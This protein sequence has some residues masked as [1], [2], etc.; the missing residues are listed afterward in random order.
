MAFRVKSRYNNII[1]NNNSKSRFSTKGIGKPIA[2]RFIVETNDGSIRGTDTEADKNLSL[3]EV[4]VDGSRIGKKNLIIRETLIDISKTKSKISIEE[5]INR[6]K[7]VETANISEFISNSKTRG[8]NVE[9]PF[10]NNNPKVTINNFINKVQ[11]DTTT[12]I[13]PTIP[14]PAQP[15]YI[16]QQTQDQAVIDAIISITATSN[17]TIS[18]FLE[19][20]QTTTTTGGQTGSGITTE[21]KIVAGETLP[22]E[23]SQNPFV[24]MAIDNLQTNNSL[25]WNGSA[26]TNGIPGILVSQLLDTTITIPTANQ[27]LMYNGTN[28]INTSLPAGGTFAIEDATNVAS[29]ADP[30]NAT[31]Y[32]GWNNTLKQWVNRKIDASELSGAVGGGG[33][34]AIDDLTD[35]ALGI[36][37]TGQVLKFNGSFWVNSSLGNIG[38][39]LD[40]IVTAPAVDQILLYNGANWVNTNFKEL[41]CVSDLCDVTVSTPTTG[42]VIQYNGSEWTNSTLPSIGTVSSW[43]IID[44]KTAGTYAGIATINTWTIREL[45]SVAVNSGTDVVLAANQITILPGNYNIDINVPFFRTN[46]TK[47]RLYNITDNVTIASSTNIQAINGATAHISTNVNIGSTKVLEIQYYATNSVDNSDLGVPMGIENEIY[48]SIRISKLVSSILTWIFTDTK[49]VGNVGG[50]AIANSWQT[51]EYNTVNLSAGPQINIFSNTFTIDPGSYH[52]DITASFYKTS[53]TKLRFRNITDGITVASS[54]N[55]FG[56]EDAT[57]NFNFNFDVVATKNYRIQYYVKNSHPNISL[58]VPSGVET[59]VYTILR[60]TKV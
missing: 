44:T 5:F 9:I 21:E 34:N 33:A 12:V 36:P 35:V 60:F 57:V 2:D 39:L 10:P 1:Q 51:R 55:V 59:E 3:R 23:F 58:G 24:D 46:N 53:E 52:V 30:N 4:N 14:D 38:D 37:T 28:W 47:I 16:V 45:N 41:I 8:N 11:Q 20:G 6:S 54:P 26:W 43:Y 49:T 17:P 29:A 22:D 42:Q 18:A 13:L 15:S 48:S 31:H 50:T 56:Y 7:V 40:V 25:I 27:V 19:P 32:L